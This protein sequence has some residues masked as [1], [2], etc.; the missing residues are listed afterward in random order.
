M[1]R[2]IPCHGLFE[3]SNLLQDWG[4]NPLESNPGDDLS[5]QLA[6]KAIPSQ[7]PT[8][9]LIRP[10]RDRRKL[11]RIKHLLFNFDYE[12]IYSP[13]IP[14]NS[15]LIEQALMRESICF[16]GFINFFFLEHKKEQI[17]SRIRACSFRSICS[18]R[19]GLKGIGGE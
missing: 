7:D 19:S 18:I 6:L 9:G 15:L 16:L 4:L 12:G 13:P 11:R 14:F 1:G 17:D 10:R 2:Y 3:N 5:F 8:L